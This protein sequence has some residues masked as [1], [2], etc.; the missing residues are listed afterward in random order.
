MPTEQIDVVDEKGDAWIVEVH[1]A[2][3]RPSMNGEG[4]KAEDGGTTLSLLNTRGH[5]LGDL[6]Q[7][8]NGTFVR[9]ATGEI[10]T[11]A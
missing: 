6:K 9:T 7:N 3:N 8:D 2:T 1:R 11:V 4:G 5:Y 10:Y